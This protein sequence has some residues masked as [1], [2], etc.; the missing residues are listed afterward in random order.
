[1]LQGEE[2]YIYIYP[3]GYSDHL[4]TCTAHSG[5]K[6]AHDWEVDHFPD[7]FRTTHKV[8][9]KQVVKIRGQSCGDIEL[10]GYLVNTSRPVPLVLDLLI[11]HDRF[12]SSSNPDFNGKLY[13]PNDMDKSLNE[14]AA[15][16]IRRYRSDY[17]NNPNSISFMPA[18]VSTSGRLHSEFIKILFL[19]SHRETDHF[20]AV[21]GVQSAQSNMGEFF[22][23]HHAAFSSMLKSRVSL[24]LAKAVALRINL[25]YPRR[26][27]YYL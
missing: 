1:L 17:N 9:T 23:F 7:L 25:S 26:V 14:T 18:I 27:A 8:K 22:H 16:K 19:Q 13:C 11:V 15:D 3:W 12:G 2:Q 24:I 6:K 20:F 5:A 10:A 21:S 4:C